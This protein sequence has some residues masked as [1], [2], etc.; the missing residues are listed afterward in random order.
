MET[1]KTSVT[2]PLP[3]VFLCGPISNALKNG[4]FDPNLR[5]LL[6]SIEQHLQ[7]SGFMVLSA[8]R[9]ERY[10]EKIP[11]LPDEVFRRDWHLA[12]LA[13]AIVAVLPSDRDGSLFRTDGT[14][15]ELGWAIALG[16]PLFI[17]TDTSATKRSYLFDGLLRA[18]AQAR[19]I[20]IEDVLKT[21]LGEAVRQV[22]ARDN[23][24]ATTNQV[25]FCCTSFGFGPVS[26]AVAVAEAL[27]LLRPGYRLVFIGSDLAEDYARSCAL[28]DEIIHADVDAEPARAV[29]YIR[30]SDALINAL[31]F[32]VLLNWSREL[33]PHFFLDSLA[34]M[35]PSIPDAVT[36]AQTY[37]VQDYL[38]GAN[39]SGSVLPKNAA[40]V[41]PIISPAI[42]APRAKWESQTGYVLVNFA[43]C[44]N[45]IF[46]P[47]YYKNYVKQML[48]ALVDALRV[49]DQRRLRP[50]NR[51]VVCG[52]RE[53]L[54]ATESVDWTG[55]SFPVER[56]FFPPREFLL[57]LRRC[58]LLLTSPG[59]TATLEAIALNVPVRFLLP[60]NYSQFRI[61]NY[62]R[63]LGLDNILWKD[64]FGS[65]RLRDPSIPEEEG[66]REVGRLLEEQLT[67]GV[68]ALS[69]VFQDLLLTNDAN[70]ET[71]TLSQ[72]VVSWDG[73][74]RV[75]QQVVQE[76]EKDQ[77]RT[78]A[79]SAS[80]GH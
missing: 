79:L 7:Q 55:L 18:S 77:L 1:N 62:Y 54:A 16:K 6:E 35:W 66:V 56:G 46:P 26:K 20:E 19:L 11:E 27:R 3:R 64:G 24:R 49:L 32:D 36:R 42:R 39:T 33:P 34:W 50:I 44:R 9:Q 4:Q 71:E 17:V 68:S 52:N 76:I 70:K 21:N 51:V 45:P 72:R 60:Q 12:Q 28:F 61:M 57:E 73:S 65:E 37:F 10:G 80:A 40:L 13:S 23:S 38:L 78:G 8:H 59:L 43:G 5:R 14:F 67:L 31:N 30:G 74:M 25:A 58:E 63:S 2:A 41:P 29:D 69:Q 15:M 47:W 48:A 22:I 75:A 53:L